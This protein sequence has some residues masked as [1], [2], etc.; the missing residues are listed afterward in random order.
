M[1]T[2]RNTTPFKLSSHL[3][4]VDW[5][6]H[7]SPDP[8]DAEDHEESGT[9]QHDREQE[10]D[11]DEPTRIWS[12]RDHLTVADVPHPK[13]HVEEP[14]ERYK[15]GALGALLLYDAVSSDITEMP[16]ASEAFQLLQLSRK[17]KTG[18][19]QESFGE[20][21]VRFRGSDDM[22]NPSVPSALARPSPTFV[23]AFASANRAPAD[24]D[25]EMADFK[26]QVSFSLPTLVLIAAVCVLCGVLL[27]LGLAANSSDPAPTGEQ[28]PALR[29]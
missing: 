19:G 16:R 20:S 21:Q 18:A 17:N 9:V 26:R 2:P 12:R 3:R 23:S 29:Q 1:R 22:T 4:P 6:E 28:T 27:A 14:T 15:P 7:G 10:R 11:E 13:P 5:G 24:F 25:T 8:N